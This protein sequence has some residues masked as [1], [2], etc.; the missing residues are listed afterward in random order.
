M[1]I[2]TSNDMDPYKSKEVI[3]YLKEELY[4]Y[5][6]S[7][8][9][10]LKESLPVVD[11]LPVI[12]EESES[13]EEDDNLECAVNGIEQKGEKVLC[14]EGKNEFTD[15]TFDMTKSSIESHTL[16]CTV[17][18]SEK[19]TEF[20]EENFLSI[21][22][23]NVSQL[24]KTNIKYYATQRDALIKNDDKLPIKDSKLI[25]L[26]EDCTLQV[27]GEE[28]EISE[29]E[30]LNTVETYNA[31]NATLKSPQVHNNEKGKLTNSQ[32]DC[33]KIMEEIGETQIQ[34]MALKNETELKINEEMEIEKELISGKFSSNLITDTTSHVPEEREPGGECYATAE[35]REEGKE[36][37]F[38]KRKKKKFSSL[39]KWLGNLCRCV[40]EK[41]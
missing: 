32:N 14:V 36:K 3:K 23:V 25:S 6:L 9:M 27:L 39:R 5:A 18:E 13:V 28:L 41:T 22:A 20:R 31:F 7:G 17:G 29:K 24:N 37:A 4:L 34:S 40:K 21:P 1:N 35:K 11:I 16:E 19:I 33:I 10:S 15:R 38:S 26:N 12:D 2:S 30:I 8:Y